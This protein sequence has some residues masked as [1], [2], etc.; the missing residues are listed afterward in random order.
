VL[1]SNFLLDW[2]LRGFEGMGEIVSELES[3]G[4]P[5]A[6]L[7]R[8]TDCVAAVLVVQLTVWVRAALPRGVWREVFA[9]STVVFAI[10]AVMAAV[11]PEPCGPGATCD[12]PAQVLQ[13][14]LH[15]YGSVVSDTALYVGVLAVILCT[16]RTGPVWFRRAAWWSLVVGGLVSSLVFGW[17]QRTEDP[18]WAVGV[19]QRVHIVCISGWILCL[20]LFAASAARTKDR[21]A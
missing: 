1:Y 18:A 3:P 13:R 15:V 4:E 2:V 11:V 14:D 8:V 10:G 6:V 16:W 20:G 5:N 7:L 12:A 19:S 21:T 17:F 9:W